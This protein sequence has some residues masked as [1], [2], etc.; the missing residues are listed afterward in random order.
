M[1]NSGELTVNPV[2]VAGVTSIDQPTISPFE[3]PGPSSVA[4][5]TTRNWSDW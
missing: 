1:T 2:V 5:D 4:L 3:V